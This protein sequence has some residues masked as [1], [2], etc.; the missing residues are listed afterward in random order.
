MVIADFGAGSGHY[1]LQCAERLE[2]TGCVY[3]IDVQRD[4]LRRIRNEAQRRGLKNIEVIAADIERPSGT[5]LAERAV[6]LALISNVLFQLEH[7]KAA[8]MEAWRI[9][10][11]SGKVAVIDWSDSFRGLGPTK[12]HVFSK[13]AALGLASETGFELLKEFHAGA[14]HYGLIF[15]PRPRPRI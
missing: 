2:G 13:D 15:K 8:L 4:L 14:H 10:K 6:D 7:P 11:P 12:K 3:A 9:V 5:H 1:A